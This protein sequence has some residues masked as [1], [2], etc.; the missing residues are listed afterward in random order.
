[1]GNYSGGNNTNWARMAVSLG[2]GIGDK[3]ARHKTKSRLSLV[4]L[5]YRGVGVCNA[6]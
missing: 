1:M 6:P 4:K 5:P 2:D 3:N